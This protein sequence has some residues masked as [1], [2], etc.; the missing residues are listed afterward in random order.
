MVP[1]DGDPAPKPG[2]SAA[3]AETVTPNPAAP[4]APRRKRPTGTQ[5]A[6]VAHEATVAAVLDGALPPLAEVSTANYQQEK[7][8]A[9]GGMGKIMSA[10]RKSV[11]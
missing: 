11:V 5:P 3:F 1:E 7:E 4:E 10:D 6:S 8:I 9:R 2:S